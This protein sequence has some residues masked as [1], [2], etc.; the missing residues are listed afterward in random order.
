[1]ILIDANLLIYARVASLPQHR[2][3][4][5][6]L[7]AKLNEPA[8]VG[9]PWPSLLGFLRIVTNPR[10]FEGPD[11][12]ESAWSQL[13]AWLDCSN[14]WIPQP[15]DSHRAI[16]TRL[17]AQARGAANLIPDTHLAALAMEH[18]LILNSTDGDFAR[19]HGLRWRNPLQDAE[20]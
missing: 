2:A 20:S 5:K 17:I 9:L 13:E 16:F 11:S 1:V 10:V 6:W 12:L 14:V 4:R 15:G 7:D 18:G 19:F 3:A 8:M